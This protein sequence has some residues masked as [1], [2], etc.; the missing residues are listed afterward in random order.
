MSRPSPSESSSVTKYQRL[1]LLFVFMKFGVGVKGL[2]VLIRATKA[3][4]GTE[5]IAPRILTLRSI[6]R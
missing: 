5:N 3:Y 1:N 6:R 2:T 4:K